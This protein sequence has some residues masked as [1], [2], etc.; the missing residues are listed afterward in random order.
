MSSCNPLTIGRPFLEGVAVVSLTAQLVANYS[1]QV[2]PVYYPNHDGIELRNASFCNVTVSYTHE[3]Q[4]DLVSVETWLPVDNWNGRLQAA[5]G[6]GLGPGRFDMSYGNMAGAIAEGYATSSTD[7]GIAN[8]L[9]PY[10]WVLDSP[11]KIDEVLVKHWGGDILNDMVFQ[12]ERISKPRINA[13]FRQS[14]RRVSSSTST[15]DPQTTPI[16]TGVLRVVVRVLN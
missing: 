5:G 14:L 15:G 4:D 10:S 12:T 9:D 6:S 13:I 1:R 8:P 3:Q 7:A 16:S 11:G 2:T